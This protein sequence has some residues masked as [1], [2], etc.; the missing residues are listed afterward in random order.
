MPLSI[1]TLSAA[2]VTELNS[3]FPIDPDRGIDPGDRD[4]FCDALAK[5]VVDHLKAS[6]VV[7]AS[8]SPRNGR[9]PP[10]ERQGDVSRRRTRNRTGRPSS[11]GRAHG[12]RIAH[13]RLPFDA[14]RRDPDR[15]LLRPEPPVPA[16]QPPAT[17]RSYGWYG[18]SDVSCRDD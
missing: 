9:R 16:G 2:M 14:A 1:S 3:S 7:D 17:C 8:V 5:A 18:S 13:G 10:R 11:S 15:R 4:E 6:A 12:I